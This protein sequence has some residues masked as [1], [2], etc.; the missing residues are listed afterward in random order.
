MQDG[1]D[2]TIVHQEDLT[3]PFTLGGSAAVQLQVA[4]SASYLTT[5]SW[6]LFGRAYSFNVHDW[7]SGNINQL[8]SRFHKYA[9]RDQQVYGYIEE[10]TETGA[11][12]PHINQ[13][14]KVNIVRQAVFDIFKTLELILQVH[15]R[16]ILDYATWYRENNKDKEAYADY[17]TL[18]TCH[19]IVH[20]NFLAP[21]IQWTLVKFSG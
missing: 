20:V 16:A 15:G 21:S 19:H 4:V 10:D 3:V 7:R 17:I 11:V 6:S 13:V 14:Q 18:V 2:M 9:P 12:T 1:P 8:C 5:I